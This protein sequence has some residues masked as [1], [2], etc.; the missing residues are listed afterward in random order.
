MRYE[1]WL[2]MRFLFAKRKEKF[3]SFSAVISV[4]GL[5]IGVAALLVVLAVMSGFTHDLREKLIGIH[6]HLLIDAPRGI[7]NPMQVMRIV[8]STEHV[9]GVSPFVAGQA[10]LQLPDQP[11]GVLVRGLDMEREHRV[12]RLAEYLVMG[13]FPQSDDEILIGSELSNLSH[14][15]PGDRLRLVSPISGK[16]HELLVSGIFRSGMYESDAYLVGITLNRAQNFYELG[17][18]VHGISVKLDTLSLAPTIKDT[19]QERLGSAYTVHTWIERNQALFGAL[20]VEKTIMF[21]IVT[22]IIVVAALN[23]VSMLTMIVMEKTKD[24]GILR[25]LGATRSSVAILFLSQGCVV[26]FLGITL[27]LIGGLALASNLNP[28]MGWLEQTFGISL[29][30][31]TIYYLDHIPTQINPIDVVWVVSVAFVLAVLAASY[32]AIRAARL[33][34]VEALRYE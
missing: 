16:T 11:F 21:I 12:S 15:L 33:V 31:P 14:A 9:V 34:P 17:D 7:S 19:L 2:A 22:L 30:P 20:Q 4:G 6:S 23:I 1:F 3:I 8:S 5:A 32:A 29:F 25:A 27:G 24:I 13:Y 18:I 26:G 28:L 10:I